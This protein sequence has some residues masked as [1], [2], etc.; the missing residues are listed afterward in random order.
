MSFSEAD[1]SDSYSILDVSHGGRY[2]SYDYILLPHK[3]ADYPES[4]PYPGT[5]LYPPV[6]LFY[7]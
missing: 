6:T 2:W 4:L 3:L 5:Q 1:L 7:I